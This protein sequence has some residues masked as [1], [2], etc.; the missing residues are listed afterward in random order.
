[1]DLRRKGVIWVDK[2]VKSGPHY[3]FANQVGMDFKKFAN[4]MAMY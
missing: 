2:K 3:Y 4:F 1:M